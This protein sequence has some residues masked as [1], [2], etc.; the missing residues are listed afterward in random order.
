MQRHYAGAIWT[1]HAHERLNQRGLTQEMAGTTF[2]HADVSM[3]G[4]QAGSIEYRK[5][6][7]RSLVTVIAK[8][9]ENGE[10][11]ILSCWIDPPM[12]G[13]EDE[14]KLHAYRDYQR[15]GFWGKV[16]K[17]VKRQLGLGY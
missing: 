1:N 17:I 10:W 16:W 3:A 6:Y 4:K 12:P 14:K 15:A 2:A 13:T 8:K 7:G 9:N 5:R 11:L